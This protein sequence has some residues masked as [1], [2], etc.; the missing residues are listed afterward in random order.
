M[1]NCLLFAS[2]EETRPACG[3][4]KR[5]RDCILSDVRAQDA[6]DTWFVTASSSRDEWRSVVSTPVRPIQQP[7]QI[8]CPVYL[9]LVSCVGDIKRHKCTA[10][11]QKRIEDQRGSYR[12]THCGRWFWSKVGLAVLRCCPPL[13]AILSS[14][15]QKLPSTCQHDGRLPLNVLSSALSVDVGGV[16]G[17]SRICHAIAL[18]ATRRLL[19]PGGAPRGHIWE[20]VSRSKVRACVRVVM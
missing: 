19:L 20:C 10:E 18:P 9:L 2:M 8:E 16:F 11:R 15:N 17:D 1:P 13:V 7:E 5:W 12:C 3:P 14:E 6:L 4:R